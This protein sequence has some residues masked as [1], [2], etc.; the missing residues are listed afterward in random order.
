MGAT[1][2]ISSILD[3]LEFSAG[4]DSH[5]LSASKDKK[6]TSMMG[7]VDDNHQNILDC[8]QFSDVEDASFTDMGLE[9]INQNSQANVEE[10]KEDKIHKE[11]KSLHIHN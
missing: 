7:S 5:L 3:K 2:V 11:D 10:E 4:E 8:I 6:D 9:F 1:S